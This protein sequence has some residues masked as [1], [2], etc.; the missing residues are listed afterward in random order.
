MLSSLSMEPWNLQA[1]CLNF[2]RKAH[3]CLYLAMLALQVCHAFQRHGRVFFLRTDQ[4][5]VFGGVAQALK[6]GAGLALAGL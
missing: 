2:W 5:L 3:N 6:L 1:K 4:Q